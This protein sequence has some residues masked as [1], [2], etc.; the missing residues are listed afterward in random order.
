MQYGSNVLKNLL[1]KN[2]LITQSMSKKGNCW[3]NAVA[4]S[5]FKTLKTVLI[6]RKSYQTIKKAELDVFE[7]IEIWYNR[8]RLHSALGY[9]TPIEVEKEFNELKEVA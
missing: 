8:K 9:K 6:Y 2:N 7:Y 3:D 1:N 4:E 5:S